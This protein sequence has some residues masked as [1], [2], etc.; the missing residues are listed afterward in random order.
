MSVQS[1]EGERTI[2]PVMWYLEVGLG[3]P[4]MQGYP[5]PLESNRIQW[6]WLEMRGGLMTWEDFSPVPAKDKDTLH[7]FHCVT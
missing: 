6:F 3:C 4:W 7:S 1:T 5:A 2:S